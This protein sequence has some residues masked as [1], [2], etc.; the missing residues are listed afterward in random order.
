MV[1]DWIPSNSWLLE[2]VTEDIVPDGHTRKITR[3]IDR[4]TF[5]RDHGAEPRPGKDKLE[6]IEIELI[7][8]AEIPS[9]TSKLRSGDLV[10]WV[11]KKEGIDIAH[12][13]MVVR[14]AKDGSVVH[15]HG[16]SKAGA[17][18]DEPLLEYAERT[19]SVFDG[20]VVLRLKPEAKPPG[21]N[22]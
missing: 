19:S 3:E 5:L 21:L 2:D 8:M 9:A 16:S 6:K 14:N 18:L 17:T 20:I 10:F 1:L 15:R 7:P 12:T 22:E 13:G 11:A 4:A